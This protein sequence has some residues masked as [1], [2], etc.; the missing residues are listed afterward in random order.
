MNKYREGVATIHGNI[1]KILRG[2]KRGLKAYEIV[3]EYARKF[4]V[5][6][7]DSAM[8]ARM[9]EMKDIKCNLSNYHYTL[10]K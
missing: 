7:S 2:R 4:K 9:R 1:R 6:Y 5:V 8:T 10:E 3:N